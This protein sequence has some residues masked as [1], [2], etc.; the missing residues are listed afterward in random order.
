MIRDHHQHGWTPMR[1]P[2]TP[3]D[4]GDAVTLLCSKEASFATG[5]SCSRST[6]ALP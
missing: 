3:A 4:I 5:Q 1:R 2:G 6:E